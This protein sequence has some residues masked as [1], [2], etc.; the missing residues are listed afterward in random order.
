MPGVAGREFHSERFQL[1]AEVLSPTN[2]R[3]EIDLKL[4]RYREA[5]ENL[6]P[7]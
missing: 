5:P 2:T 1:V 3:P 4:R 6:T 7:S